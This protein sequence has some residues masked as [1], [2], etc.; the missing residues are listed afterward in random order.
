MSK[1]TNDMHELKR[2]L[3]AVDQLLLASNSNDELRQKKIQLAGIEQTILKLTRKETPIPAD[4]RQLKLNLLNQV[5]EHKEAKIL[6]KQLLH[7]CQQ[8]INNHKDK[9]RSVE[10]PTDQL[11]L[12]SNHSNPKDETK[13]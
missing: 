3:Q 13:G 7:L 12:F 10:A 4:L 1:L 11:T 6:K 2:L 5:E 9:R 8:F